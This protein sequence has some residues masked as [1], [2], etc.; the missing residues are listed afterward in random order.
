MQKGE[1]GFARGVKESSVRMGV[2]V[3]IKALHA[4]WNFLVD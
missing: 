3:S 4:L 2:E 1:Q